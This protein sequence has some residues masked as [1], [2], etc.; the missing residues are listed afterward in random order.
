MAQLQISDCVEVEPPV[1][2]FYSNT[3]VVYKEAEIWMLNDWFRFS[4]LSRELSTTETIV[5]M[6]MCRSAGY[7]EKTT[8]LSLES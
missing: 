4:L 2:Y 6:K 1:Q 8:T 3:P 5:N 7:P